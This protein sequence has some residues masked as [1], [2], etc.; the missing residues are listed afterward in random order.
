MRVLV[1][2]NLINK[3]QLV[4]LENGHSLNGDEYL[5]IIKLLN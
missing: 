3:K 5:Y 2:L 4:I 1:D